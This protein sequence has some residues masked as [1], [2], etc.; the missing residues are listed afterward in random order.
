MGYELFLG[1]QFYKLDNLAFLKKFIE[2]ISKGLEKI[3]IFLTLQNLK[4]F[5]VRFF[6]VSAFLY[7]FHKYFFLFQG[8]FFFN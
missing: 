6:E 8:F 2:S 5:A 1:M 7:R 3:S 4:N